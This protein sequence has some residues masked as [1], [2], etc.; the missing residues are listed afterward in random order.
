[1]LWRSKLPGNSIMRFATVILLAIT[2]TFAAAQTSDPYLWLE[3]VD[4]Q[5]ALNWVR[6]QDAA[7]LKRL[8]SDPNYKPFYNTALKLAEAKDRIPE[9][10][11]IGGQVYNFWQDASH[12]QGIWRRT[13]L[14][15][16]RTA[17]PHW[18]TVLDLDALSKQEH[19]NWVWKGASCWTPEDRLCLV[20]LSGG[21]E[22]AVTTREFD[23]ASTRFVPGGFTLPRA[24]QE[25][26]WENRDTL[27]VA[28]DWGPGSMTASGYPFIVKRLR[29]GQ[30]LAQA[31]EIYRG[32]PQ[33]VSVEIDGLV[34]GQ[35]DHAVVL[36][37]GI[38]FFRSETRLVTPDTTVKL[39]LPEKLDIDGLLRDRL[40][41]TLNQSF[42]AG[43]GTIPAGSLAALDLTNPDAPLQ[44]IFVP[45]P[46][47]TIDEAS[48]SKDELI[49]AVYDNVRGRA[50][51]FEPGASGWS[52]RTL[53]LPDNSSIYLV[54]SNVRDDRVFIEA[55]SFLQPSALYLSDLTTSS[56]PE[57]VRTRPAKFDAAN[58]VVQ[59]FEA[60]S[61]DGTKIPYFL[62]H[63][64]NM[65]LNGTNPTLLYGYGGF[66]ISMTPTYSPVLGKLWLERGGVYA[67]ANIRGGG[68]F[69]PAW[70]EAALKT[71]RQLAF[72]DFAAVARDLI[73]RK[74]T[75]PRHLGIRGGSNGG[76]LM[77]VEFTQHPALFHAVI[78]EVPLLDMLRFEQIA[79]GA[80]WVGEYGSVSV[81]AERAFLAKI[82]PYNNLKAGV[83]YP[84]PF[85]FT[86][87]KDDRVGPQHA[88][89]F[90]AKLAELH[91]PYFYYEAIEGGHSA[92][93]NLRETAQEQALEL[94][95][96]TE[97]LVK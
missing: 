43:S 83:A 78:I 36:Q 46:R 40:I 11:L 49:A 3:K 27:I 5:R 47:Q 23:L 13:S 69:G 57:M 12:V 42:P 28:T 9:P 52:A 76:L 89:K 7:S 59:Q 66:Q 68:E 26:A 74:V 60:T 1:M 87:T 81:P 29:R 96:L 48:T 50:M 65:A 10:S 33:D 72:D 19:K 8:E 53:D 79:A 35:G 34:D 20:S 77:G 63:P 92:G 91:R 21:G 56:A 41:V 54:D 71:H 18:A 75:D 94:T 44:Q 97:K 67:L 16:Y 93:A 64:K 62:V 86:T 85:I 82:S 30:T 51:V 55:Q 32:K 24:K 17:T 58:D 95:Y 80:S 39:D 38:D 22:D 90:A 84:E 61:T 25:F 6:Q 2:P 88:R 70:H 4:S 15:D 37:R 45:G 31:T 14:T 73:A